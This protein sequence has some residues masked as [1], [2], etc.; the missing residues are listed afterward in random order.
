VDVVGS[1]GIARLIEA[2][3]VEECIDIPV[4]DLNDGRSDFGSSLSFDPMD[5]CGLWDNDELLVD[6]IS[7]STLDPMR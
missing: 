4:L 7:G 6:S 1:P 3:T 5:H 2:L